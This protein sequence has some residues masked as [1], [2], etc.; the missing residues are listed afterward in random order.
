MTI[1]KNVNQDFSETR[2]L[3]KLS[4]VGK[5]VRIV[6]VTRKEQ[7]LTAFAMLKPVLVPV[8]PELPVKN[9]MNA[10]RSIMVLESI[11][12]AVSKGLKYEII[13][14]LNDFLLFSN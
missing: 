3:T 10:N 6:N 4:K 7:F 11:K 1:V 5:D 9:A 13:N 14:R 8:K 12:T 2:S